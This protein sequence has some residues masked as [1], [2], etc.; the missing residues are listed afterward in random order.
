MDNNKQS[1]KINIKNPGNKM[2]MAF[3]PG[4]DIEGANKLT[5]I[6][7][8]NFGPFDTSLNNADW[9]NKWLRTK[10]IFDEELIVFQYH[11]I[12]KRIPLTQPATLY[13]RDFFMTELD[14]ELSR[15]TEIRLTVPHGV[16]FE[17]RFEYEKM[18][19]TEQ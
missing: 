17:I 12:V 10:A 14:I 4:R 13:D 8:T 9:D 1:T 18:T 16:N 3:Y 7:I 15:Y 19:N 6:S 2:Q 11:D 5:G